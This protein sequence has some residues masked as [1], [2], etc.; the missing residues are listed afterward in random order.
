MPSS[1]CWCV[2]VCCV[3]LNDDVLSVSLGFETTVNG[4]NSAAE[5]TIFDVLPARLCERVGKGSLIRPIDNRLRQIYIGF[6]V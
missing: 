3:L 6:R 2:A 4:N 1:V 5:I